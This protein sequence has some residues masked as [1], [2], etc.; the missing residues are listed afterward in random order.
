MNPFFRNVSGTNQPL[1]PSMQ[2]SNLNHINFLSFRLTKVGHDI[3]TR[4]REKIL[5]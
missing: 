5:N 4:D 3:V 1:H 2:T